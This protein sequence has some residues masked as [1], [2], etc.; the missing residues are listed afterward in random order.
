VK[1]VVIV[2]NALCLLLVGVLVSIGT[3]RV[4]SA[5]PTQ[6]ERVQIELVRLG[7]SADDAAQRVAALD[8][9]ELATIAQKLDEQ[10]AGQGLLA[11]VLIA[12][13]A[14]FIMLVI[15]DA[16]GVTDVFPWIKKA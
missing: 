4:A 14:V 3:P 1:A 13:G 6:A 16:T 10:P 15:L 8:E 2:R 11:T 9:S 12:A 5:E 7:V